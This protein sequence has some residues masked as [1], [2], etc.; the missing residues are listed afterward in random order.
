MEIP[1]EIKN[2]TKPAILEKLA[3]LYHFLGIISLTTI[4]G[5]IN[6]RDICDSKISWDKTIPDWIVKKWEKRGEIPT[7]VNLPRTINL[8]QEVL[9]MIDIHVFGDACLLGTCAVAYGVMRQLSIG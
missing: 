4:I 5:K 9:E 2:L 7:K 1:S 3:L 6:Y 8:R